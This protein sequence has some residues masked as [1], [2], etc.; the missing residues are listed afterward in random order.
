[1]TIPRLLVAQETTDDFENTVAELDEL[2]TLR[3]MN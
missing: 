1:M 2:E 3:T